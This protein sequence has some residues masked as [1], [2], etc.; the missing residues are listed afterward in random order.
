MQ[1][2]I[3]V[4]AVPCPL[5]WI[6]FPNDTIGVYS[7]FLLFSGVRI[8]FSTFPLSVLKYFKVHISQLVP[9]GLNKVVSFEVVYHDLGIVPTMT[10]FRVFQVL[11]KQGDWFSFDIW[12]LDHLTWRLFICIYDDL[13]ID[14][15]IHID[16]ERVMG[17]RFNPPPSRVKRGGASSGSG[18]SSVWLNKK[19]DLVFRKKV[20]DADAKIVE[21][22][23][24]LPIPL[25]DRVSQHT[26][27]PSAEGVPISLPTPDEEAVKRELR[28]LGSGETRTWQCIDIVESWMLCVICGIVWFVQEEVCDSIAKAVMN[29]KVD[30]PKVGDI[31]LLLF[32]L[33]DYVMCSQMICRGLP[34][35]T[36]LSSELF[37]SWKR[38]ARQGFLRPSHFPFRR[39]TSFVTVKK[40]SMEFNL[41]LSVENY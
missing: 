15:L 38:L 29:V 23:H 11:Y 14:V 8:R 41:K 26:T 27:A 33:R 37:G 36:G 21:E 35:M 40:R 25:L 34:H 7:E 13:P 2:F 20:D 3:I 16:V 1:S 10:L 5:P 39:S 28:R 18:L 12:P 31:L 24:H 30:A 4:F 6:V 32:L 22:L 17:S 9:L 19:Y